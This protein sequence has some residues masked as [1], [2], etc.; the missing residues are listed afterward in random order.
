M[1]NRTLISSTSPSWLASCRL[2]SFLAI[3]TKTSTKKFRQKYPSYL[4]FVTES[5]CASFTKQWSNYMRLVPRAKQ[6]SIS[7]LAVWQSCYH[8]SLTI[9]QP[10]CRPIKNLFLHWLVMYSGTSKM[11]VR[12]KSSSQRTFQKN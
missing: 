2:S 6:Q 10:K 9:S 12:W 11:E 7:N 8:K 3:F 1:S 4:S 5:T